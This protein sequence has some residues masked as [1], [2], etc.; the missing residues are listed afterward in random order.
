MKGGYIVENIVLADEIYGLVPGNKSTNHCPGVIVW[1]LLVVHLSLVEVTELVGSWKPAKSFMGVREMDFKGAEFS[2]RKQKQERKCALSADG[3]VVGVQID[4]LKEL[5]MGE[6]L[7]SLNFQIDDQAKT[8]AGEEMS[9][10]SANAP[11]ADSI[12]VLL[13]QALHADDDSLLLNCLFTQVKKARLHIYGRRVIANSISLLSPS[14]V[15]KL[16][17]SLIPII[18]S[19]FDVSFSSPFLIESRV[20]TSRSALQLASYLDYLS[21]AIF[22]DGDDETSPMTPIVFEDN[23]ESSEGGEESAD[24]MRE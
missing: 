5:T 24:D 6:K 1:G 4:D 17:H 9:A 16:F 23:D 13:K 10:P 14:D 19:R 3:E 20:A 12:H 2:G 15:M 11:R 18:Q 22:E 21:A 8:L 7:G